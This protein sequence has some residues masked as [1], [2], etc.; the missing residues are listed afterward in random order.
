MRLIDADLLV[1][2]INKSTMHYAE[3]LWKQVVCDV[4]SNQPTAYNVD[5]VVE[6]LEEQRSHLP[7]K[8]WEIINKS[9]EIVKGGGVNERD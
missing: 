4:I 2:A 7:L 3:H 8:I 9:I 5:K 1:D 6:E